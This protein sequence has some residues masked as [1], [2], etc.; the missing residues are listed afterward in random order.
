MT[1][2]ARENRKLDTVRKL[3]DRANHPSTPEAEAES[4]KARAYE[5]MARY[6]IDEAMLEDQQISA[7]D[8]DTRWIFVGAPYAKE[9][10]VLLSVIANQY[11][12]R[13]IGYPKQW[14]YGKGYEVVRDKQGNPVKDRFGETK[15]RRKVIFLYGKGVD[16]KLYGFAG[17]LERVEMLFTTLLLHMTSDLGK[18]R[19]PFGE[20]LGTFRAS[21]VL[22][23][24]GEIKRRLAEMHRKAT[25]DTDTSG[26]RGAELVLADRKALVDQRFEEDNADA[27]QSGPIS[28][29]GSGWGDG[30]R[31]GERADLGGQR[32][33]NPQ[34]RTA[35]TG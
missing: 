5:L 35:L 28:S 7:T 13:M 16:C 32:V 17:D 3:L 11:G 30:R 34:R 1:D 10:R 14:R 23:F 33:Q 15:K 18:A 12:C 9:K 19:V 29:S 2:E 25:A 24:A 21:F 22:G 26:G 4:S 31:S 20:D 6:Q 8:V 27:Y